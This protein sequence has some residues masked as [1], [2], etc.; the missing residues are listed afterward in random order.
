MD[1]YENVY[2]SKLLG[3]LV[4]NTRKNNGLTLI[5]LSEITGLSVNT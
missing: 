2:C 3:S 1:K 4:R 5:E